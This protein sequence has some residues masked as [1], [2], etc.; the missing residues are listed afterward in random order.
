[1]KT[2]IVFRFYIGKGSGL[3]GVLFQRSLLEKY[4]ESYSDEHPDETPILEIIQKWMNFF[5]GKA[6]LGESNLEQAFNEDFFIKI[7]GYVGPP[8]EQFNFLPKQTAMEG[9]F[10]PDFLMGTFVLK[11]GKIVEDVRRVVGEL[12]GPQTSLDRIDPSRKKTPVEQ[13]FDYARNNGIF[14][15]WVIVSNLKTIRL[16]RNSSMWDYNEIRINDFVLHDRLTKEFWEFYYLLHHDYF[17]KEAPKTAVYNLLLQNFETRVKLTDSFYR[18]YREILLDTY[19]AIENQC[20]DLAKTKDGQML[21]A[22][23]AQKLLHRGLLVCFM[24]DHPQRLL[25]KGILQDVID[26]AQSYPTL[27][28]DKIFLALKDFFKCINVGSPKNYL[29]QIFGYDGSLFAFDD[30]IDKVELPDSLFEKEYDLNGKKVSGIFGFRAIDFYYEFSPHL[31]GR[32]FEHSINDQEEMFRNISIR[33]KDI[34]DSFNLQRELGV[35]Y[36]RE[37]LANFAAQCVLSDT[38]NEIRDD[39][40]ETIFSKKSFSE[41]NA[42]EE[43]KFWKSYMEKL[44]NIKILDLAVGSGAFLVACY[45]ILRREIA[46]AFEMQKLGLKGL[47]K[48]FKTWESSLLDKCLHGKDIMPDAISIAKLALWIAS[49][50]K[51]VPLKDFKKNFVVGDSLDKP[52]SFDSNLDA[53]GGNQQFDIVIG[54]PPWGA[55][56]NESALNY[57]KTWLH[58]VDDITKLDSYELFIHTALRFLKK[59]G[60]LCYIL[61]HTLLY[62]EKEETRRYVVDNFQIERWHYLGSD[63]FGPDIRMNTTLLQLKKEKATH[64]STYHSMTL[65]GEDRRNAINGRIDL[66]QLEKSYSYSIPQ[67]RSQK[68]PSASVEL[69]RYVEDDPILSKME[70]KSVELSILCDR[71]RGV[72]LNKAGIIVQCPICGKWIPPP[73][74]TKDK[75]KEE[76]LKKCNYCSHEFLWKQALSTDCIVSEEGK[77]DVPYIDGDSFSGR[78]GTLKYKTLKLSYDGINY[79]T[80]SLYEKPKVFIRQAGV[81]LSVAYDEKDAY[82]PQSVY[83]YRIKSDFPDVEHKLLLAVLQSRSFAYYVFKKF[84]EIDASQ[85]FSKLTHVRL[86][87]L[88]IPVSD[89]KEKKWQEKQN[90]LVEVVDEMLLTREIG[91]KEDWKIERIVQELYGLEPSEVAHITS[92]LGL[93][94]YHKAMKEMFPKGPPPKPKVLEEIKMK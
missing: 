75:P 34:L 8:S 52:I 68:S 18:H 12:K 49:I 10:I 30:I 56:I 23:S 67:E 70:S 63:W 36:T 42:D 94:G 47:Q 59:G 82:C 77:Y 6:D 24:S 62:P 17:L 92:Q 60:R 7:L 91:G 4:I 20:H 79:K 85:A 54:N 84:G 45:N 29:Y 9:Q 35:I 16:Y 86:G 57:M 33:G 58:E 66:T 3:L 55:E 81:G 53:E 64:E 61:P 28:T 93:V 5:K 21:I 38:F 22:Q 11:E 32:L 15:D 40:L 90:E 88:P 31:L 89:H 48:Y 69:F 14:V 74:P 78:Y 65:V 76:W 41:L 25:P 80:S 71:G 39:L 83:I 87:K 19:K 46:N 2:Y 13:A 43:G 1:M 27:R 51:D 26:G 73:T 44:L 37:V 72:E 50:H